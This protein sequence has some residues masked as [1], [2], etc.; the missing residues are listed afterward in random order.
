MAQDRTEAQPDIALEAENKETPEEGQQL[1]PDQQAHVDDLVRQ[2]RNVVLA[3]VGRLTRESERAVKAA[4]AAGERVKRML[5]EQDDVDLEAAEGSSEIRS[6]QEVKERIRRRQVEVELDDT[7]LER[8]SAKEELSQIKVA[9]VETTKTQAA[10]EIATRLNVDAD[11]LIDAAK[12]TDG[13]KEAMEALANLQPKKEVRATVVSDSGA[14]SGG[15][16]GGA[17][18]LTQI[19]NMPDDEYLKNKDAI[20]RAQ[21]EG[22]IKR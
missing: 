12:F 21:R 2:A 16:G 11:K 7:K 14:G 22:K 1:T 13:S 5:K 17:F 8:D 6:K 15:G 4:T 3:D 10:R 19:D 20:D 9:S 18:T